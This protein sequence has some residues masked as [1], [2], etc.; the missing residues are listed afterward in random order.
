[1]LSMRRYANEMLFRML[2]IFIISNNPVL[3][4]DAYLERV[5]TTLIAHPPTCNF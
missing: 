4:V 3:Y 1:M 2:E 5:V